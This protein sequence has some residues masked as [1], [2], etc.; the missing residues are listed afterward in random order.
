MLPATIGLAAVQV[1]IF[2]S[3]IYASHEPGAVS[4]LNYAFRIL[5][6]PI[7]L[8]GV[9][10][11]TIAGARL[12]RSAAVGDQGGVRETVR[13]SL[14]M[15]AFL[16]VPATVGLLVLGAPVVRLLYE[17]GRFS[18]LDTQGTASALGLYALGLVAY[19]GVKVLAPAFYALGSPRVPL[20]GSVLAVATNLAILVA[21]YERF[22][23]RGVA[24]G[25]AAGSL[26]NVAVLIGVL[27]RRLGGLLRR[28][29]VVG[30]ARMILAS[31]LMAAPAA[32]LSAALEARFGTAGLTAQLLTG[33]LPVTLGA[34][35]YGV[36]AFALRVPQLQWVLSAVRQRR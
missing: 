13:Q 9:A 17:R 10:I 8:F 23:Y 1:N 25:T 36:A 21:S 22:G 33:L 4:W 34:V 27:E 2:V 24:L 15:V 19:T 30:M 31:A 29:A 35:L 18:A 6:L 20:L 12:A 32:W 28:G 16:T 11:G 3:G 14:G 7:G 26:V 5:Y